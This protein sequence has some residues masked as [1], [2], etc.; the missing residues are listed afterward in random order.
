M[1][2]AHFFCVT[3]LTAFA[4]FESLLGANAASEQGLFGD[5]AASEQSPVIPTLCMSQWKTF[6][7][8]RYRSFLSLHNY[9]INMPEIGKS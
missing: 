2:I 6:S 1:K 8:N 4:H 9:P 5:N 3:C 7:W